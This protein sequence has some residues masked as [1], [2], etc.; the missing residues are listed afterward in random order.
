MMEYIRMIKNVIKDFI[1]Q[2]NNEI[3]KERITDY[4]NDFNYSKINE[5]YKF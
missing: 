3:E 4:I 2:V 1:V 5:Y